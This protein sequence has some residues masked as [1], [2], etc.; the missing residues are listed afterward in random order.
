MSTVS[1]HV[2]RSDD[3]GETWTA[4][5]SGLPGDAILSLAVDFTH[6]STVYAALVRQVLAGRRDAYGT[7]IQRHRRSAYSVAYARVGQHAD[8]ED[9]A[10]ESFLKALQS[11]DTL[12][13]PERFAA[14]LTGIVRHCA[15]RVKERQL[16]EVTGEVSSEVHPTVL[17]DYEREELRAIVRAARRA[18]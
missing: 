17:P 10:Q 18:R 12:R 1:L 8:A 6:P 7:L 5:R 3:A 11:L 13:D 15:S 4:D 14:W 9:V 16:R 2:F